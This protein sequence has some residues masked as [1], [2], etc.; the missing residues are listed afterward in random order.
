MGDVS[1]GKANPG[2]RQP[3]TERVTGRAIQ[4]QRHGIPRN[5]PHPHPSRCGAHLPSMTSLVWKKTIRRRSAS[6]TNPKSSLS[7]HTN[8]RYGLSAARSTSATLHARR[9]PVARS[10]ATWNRTRSPA[11]S[12]WEAE[13][14]VQS[15]MPDVLLYKR[16]HQEIR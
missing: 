2:A 5:N 13:E 6:S 8:P 14:L 1:G 12:F 10:V 11:F 15:D 4:H 9:F 3:Y 7:T 16:F